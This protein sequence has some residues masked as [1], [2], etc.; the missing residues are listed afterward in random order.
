MRV[1]LEFT[2]DEINAEIPYALICETRY[3]SRWN[4][5]SVRRRWLSSFTEEERKTASKLFAQSHMWYLKTGVPDT[6]CM[7]KKTWDL[8]HKLGEFCGSI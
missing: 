8:W 4:T 7:S 1:L 5:G 2:R 6:V 3:G